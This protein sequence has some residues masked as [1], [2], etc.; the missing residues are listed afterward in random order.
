MLVDGVGVP[1]A[2]QGDEVEIVLDRTPFYAEGGGQLADQGRLRLDSGAVV[3]VRDVQTPLPGLTVHRGQVVSGE[4]VVGDTAVAEVDV[5]RRRAIS[6]AHT[7]THLVHKAFRTTLGETATQAGSENAPGALPLRLLLAHRRAADR[8][9]RRGAGG[10]RGPVRG[11]GR[12]GRDH[13]PGAG[14]RRGG[15]GAVR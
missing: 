6:R 10:Q 14:A 9:A 12:A 7:A 4:V 5:E 15:H 1:A 13:E 11:P 2:S 8:A 3:D